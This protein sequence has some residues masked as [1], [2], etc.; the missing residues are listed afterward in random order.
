MPDLTILTTVLFD[1]SDSFN[2]LATIRLLHKVYAVGVI[3]GL[4]ILVSAQDIFHGLSRA[5]EKWEHCLQA[6]VLGIKPPNVNSTPSFYK[7]LQ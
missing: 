6:P 2:P 4:S 7:A 3:G 5:I 1:F